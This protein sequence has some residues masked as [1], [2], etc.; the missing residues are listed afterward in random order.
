MFASAAIVSAYTD[1]ASDSTKITFMSLS[2]MTSRTS[3]NSAG[4]ISSAEV[5]KLGMMVVRTSTP[6]LA[7]K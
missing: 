2:S 1:G 7:S 4:D 3:T 6:Y 5:Y